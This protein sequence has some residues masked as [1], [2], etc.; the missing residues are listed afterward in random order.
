[1]AIAP[2]TFTFKSRT[3]ALEGDL[4]FALNLDHAAFKALLKRDRVVAEHRTLVQGLDLMLLRDVVPPHHRQA[5]ALA[6]ID[7]QGMRAAYRAAQRPLPGALLEG[8]VV[9]QDVAAETASAPTEAVSP[10]QMEMSIVEIGRTHVSAKFD[11]HTLVAVMQKDRP[12]L[13]TSD[14]GKA[15]GYKADGSTLAKIIRRDWSDEFREGEHYDVLRGEEFAR[16]RQAM[17]HAN[18][19]FSPNTRTVNVIYPEG[20]LLVGSKTGKPLGLLLERFIF[21]QVFPALRDARR[22]HE[23]QQLNLPTPQPVAVESS[24]AAP[25]LTPSDRTS[26][27]WWWDDLHDYL[28]RCI[29]A[30]TMTEEAVLKQLAPVYQSLVN[31]VGKQG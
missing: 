31:L 12:C 9:A 2:P 22:P 15:L 16:V 30:G 7:E 13:L 21:E 4:A 23:M 18:Y 28:N 1:M 11:R 27:P 26:R 17:R 8:D 25:V 19:V 29:K 24:A 6:I 20:I 14:I 10:A 3:Y 5:P